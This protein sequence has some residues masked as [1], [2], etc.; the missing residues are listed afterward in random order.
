M[1][2]CV[3]ELWDLESQVS[4]E[5]WALET[6]CHRK[7]VSHHVW[8][9]SPSTQAA[10]TVEGL[11]MGPQLRCAWEN[12]G[13]SIHLCPKKLFT[14]C[15]LCVGH[16]RFHSKAQFLPWRSTWLNAET[17][18]L[19][20]VRTGN[21]R[22]LEN[23]SENSPAEQGLQFSVQ[24]QRAGQVGFAPPKEWKLPQRRRTT[25]G[26]DFVRVFQA[27][28]L[29]QSGGR[30]W[31]GDVTDGSQRVSH[32]ALVHDVPR[33]TRVPLS[34]KLGNHL[35]LYTSFG[36]FVMHTNPYKVLRSPAIKKSV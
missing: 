30:V 4:K 36:N 32:G 3:R 15:L 8:L 14:M 24:V 27:K 21:T 34:H 10:R 1:R 7:H 9:H 29:N 31:G 25:V 11:E 19:E 23:F 20:H 5:Q 16:C 6:E 35:L 13:G 17:F 33:K 22:T 2:L 18:S 26:G 28:L 12:C